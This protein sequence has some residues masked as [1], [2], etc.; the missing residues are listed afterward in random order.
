[1]KRGAIL[2]V[3][4]LVAAAREAPTAH[5]TGVRCSSFARSARSALTTVPARGAMIST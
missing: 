5:P 2:I 3:L 1:M 4:A